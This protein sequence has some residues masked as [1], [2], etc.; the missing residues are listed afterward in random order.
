[1]EHAIC[2]RCFAEARVV[3]YM[4]IKSLICDA[5]GYDEIEMLEV[6]P[7]ERTSKVRHSPYK[8]GGH[9]RTAKV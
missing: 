7:E 4:G 8:I 9:R 5:C 6:Y 2:P 1:M 3:E